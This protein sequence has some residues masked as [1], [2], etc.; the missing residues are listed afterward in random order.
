MTQYGCDSELRPFEDVEELEGYVQWYRNE[1]MVQ[2]G[3][4]RCIDY[5]TDFMSQA[6]ADGFLVSTEVVYQ[7]YEGNL[8]S[9]T[10]HMMNTTVIGGNVWAIDISTGAIKLFGTK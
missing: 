9:D 1:K 5:A 4:G 10:L 6:I 2:Y 3:A 8:F 7:E